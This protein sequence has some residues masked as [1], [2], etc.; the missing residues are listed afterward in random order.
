MLKTEQEI[1]S[2]RDF[3]KTH[4]DVKLDIGVDMDNTFDTD[5]FIELLDVKDELEILLSLMEQ[6]LLV[7][8]RLQEYHKAIYNSQNS[9]TKESRPTHRLLGIAEMRVEKYIMQFQRLQ[10]ASR[11][12]QEAVCYV[13]RHLHF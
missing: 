2:C 7:I 13:L 5:G 12:A 11:S 9:G 8:R 10:G 4:K 1:N 6:Q 3:E